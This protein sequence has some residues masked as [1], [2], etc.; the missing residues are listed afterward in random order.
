MTTA[1]KRSKNILGLRN[2]P[3]LSKKKRKEK[4]RG[5]TPHEVAHSPW[6]EPFWGCTDRMCFT[7]SGPGGPIMGEAVR[8]EDAGGNGQNI[9]LAPGPRVRFR[10][11]R[12]IEWSIFKPNKV[13]TKRFVQNREKNRIFPALGPLF[14]ALLILWY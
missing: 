11:G 14:F 12:L 7:P 2:P 13:L 3:A 8:K 6:D 10:R 9:P 5:E 4:W 1:S